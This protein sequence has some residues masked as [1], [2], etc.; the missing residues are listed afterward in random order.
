MTDICGL[1]AGKSQ[2]EA[3]KICPDCPL[4]ECRGATLQ[5]SQKKVPAAAARIPAKSEPFKFI[6]KPPVKPL[7]IVKPAAAVESPAGKRFYPPDRAKGT[8][9]A[10]FFPASCFECKKHKLLPNNCMH[11][12]W[13]SPADIR[14]CKEQSIWLLTNLTDL[15]DGKWPAESSSYVDPGASNHHFRAKANFE[16]AIQWSAEITRRL[17]ACQIDG[18]VT[19]MIYAFGRSEESMAVYTKTDVY[20]VRRRVDAVIKYISRWNM[21]GIYRRHNWAERPVKS[22]TVSNNVPISSQ[23]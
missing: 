8:K 3:I 21:K 17:E 19:L 14:L 22:S 6:Y 18:L 12:E 5:G 13:F 20:E 7:V 9:P 16:S 1:I 10:D 2:D 4:N 11:P 15:R 23:S